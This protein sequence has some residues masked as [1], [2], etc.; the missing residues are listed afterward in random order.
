MWVIRH[1]IVAQCQLDYWNEADFQTAIVK[2]VKQTIKMISYLFSCSCC[3]W[4]R[5]TKSSFSLLNSTHRPRSFTILYQS[6]KNSIPLLS[7]SLISSH[8]IKQSEQQLATTL[9]SLADLLVPVSQRTGSFLKPLF[10]FNTNLPDK[11]N[12]EWYQ[13]FLLSYCLTKVDCK[14]CQHLQHTTCKIYSIPFQMV[15]PVYQRGSFLYLLSRKT[16]VS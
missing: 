6:A 4:S 1:F 3:I 8:L 5:H 9:Y 12:I 13:R 16:A 15:K 10:R 7:F 11:S 14:M 2:P